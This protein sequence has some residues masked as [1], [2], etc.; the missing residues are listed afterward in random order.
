M[1]VIS[2]GKSIWC[3]YD[4]YKRYFISFVCGS[5][6]DLVIWLW[7]KSRWFFF[8]FTRQNL[9]ASISL[10]ISKHRK[11]YT[12]FYSKQIVRIPHK[13]KHYTVYIY[14]CIPILH[15]VDT[16]ILGMLSCPWEKIA[17]VFLHFQWLPDCTA[18]RRGTEHFST[19]SITLLIMIFPQFLWI[20]LAW[21]VNI[22]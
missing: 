3:Y 20:W 18:W 4:I 16:Q 14:S 11:Y 17:F 15:R 1:L 21:H 22:I 19:H 6:P 12:T 9:G 8:S 7:R 5:L 2:R 13:S 10:L